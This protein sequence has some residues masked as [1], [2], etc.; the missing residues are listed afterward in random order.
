MENNFDAIVIGGG[1]AGVESALALARMKNK[2]LLI[3]LNFD[4]VSFL[5]CNPSIGGTA[6]GQLVSEIDALGG[7]MGKT[8]DKSCL[9][10]RML[11]G[12]KGPAVRSLRAQVDKDDYHK[13]MLDVLKNQENLELTE[14]EASVI[15]TDGEKVTG[16]KTADGREFKTKAVVIC[17]GVYLNSRT[18]TG[19]IIKDEG[20]AGFSNSK[21]LT[22]SLIDLGF[23]I[24][25]FKTGTPPRLNHDTIDYTKFE[26]QRGED[27]IQTFSTMTETKP[28]NILSCYLGYTNETTH[29]IILD[30][31]DKAP[32]YSGTIVGVGPRYCPSIETKIVRFKDKNRHQLFLEPETIKNDSIY[33]QGFSTS[34]PQDIQ[35]KMVGSI[36]GLENTKI[37]KFG[38]AIEYDAI[39]CTDLYPTLGFKKIKGIYTAGQINGTSGYEEAGAQGI[40]AGI[41]AG[42]YLKGKDELVLSRDSSYI[43]VLIDD[44][45]TKGTNEPYRMMTS[46]AEFRL[47]LRQ[48]NADMRLTEIGRKVGLVDDLRYEK[49]KKKCADLERARKVLGKILKPTEEM[50]KFLSE[51]NETPIVTGITVETLIRRTN[52]TAKLINDKFGVFEGFADEIIDEINIEVK[53]SG[54]IIKQLQVIEKNRKLENK[55]LSKGFDY[56]KIK[57]LRLEA[58]QKLNDVKPLTVGQASRISG[59]SPADISVLLF[60]LK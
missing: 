38:Y 12:S 30:N 56:S 23:K 33:L 36:L 37:L 34:M 32:M 10:L 27:G 49:F 24:V 5:A 13:T 45:V 39:D 42:L 35:E 26:E 25:R 46:R 6:K 41:N 14:G 54:Y 53:Y 51:N 17:T 7:E 52:L 28:K 47:L 31:L 3:T 1:H 55:P 8:A 57:G 44:L 15:L 29:K 9:Q 4:G 16:V 21:N 43:G 60:N 59:V 11:N 19:E 20:P 18:I 40:V 48:D 50:N 22:Q 58:V 2:T